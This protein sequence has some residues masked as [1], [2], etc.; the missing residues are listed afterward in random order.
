MFPVPVPVNSSFTQT[1]LYRSCADGPRKS[2]TPPRKTPRV[3][4][5]RTDRAGGEDTVRMWG[6]DT[7]RVGEDTVRVG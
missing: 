2:P 4:C 6:K 7:V 3:R 5:R 1:F